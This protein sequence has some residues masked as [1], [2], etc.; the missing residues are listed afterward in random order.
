MDANRLRELLEMMPP[1]LAEGSDLGLDQAE[2]LAVR[3]AAADPEFAAELERVQAWD[4]RLA[5]A[6]NNV[7]IPAGLAERLMAAVKAEEAATMVT[8]AEVAKPDA[9]RGVPRRTWLVSL[10]ASAALIAVAV[11]GGSYA[12]LLGSPSTAAIVEES[13]ELWL[14]QMDGAWQETFSVASLDDY[15]P[16]GRLQSYT[17]KAWQNVSTKLD[18]KAVVYKLAI[19]N[20]RRAMLL[21]MQSPR[22]LSDLA[23]WPK[24]NPDFST[25][26]ICIGAWQ[27]GNLVYVLMVEG[28]QQDYERLLRDTDLT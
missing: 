16:S 3:E 23:K 13:R 15:H 10:A 8:P 18:E 11:I 14:S 17:V 28:N 22:T 19:P 1:D 21:V 4:A 26:G 25:Q 2:A 5:R 9:S 24:R 6:M 27:E 7:P 20:R 12:W